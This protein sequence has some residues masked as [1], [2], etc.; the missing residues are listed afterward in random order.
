MKL[1][2]IILFLYLLILNSCTKESTTNQLV[3]TPP[4]T[5]IPSPPNTNPPSTPTISVGQLYQGGMVIHIFTSG[6]Y[7]YISGQTH[8]II[9][10]LQN[11]SGAFGSRVTLLNGEKIGVA[12][13]D[14]C[15]GNVGYAKINT[16]RIIKAFTTFAT[17]QNGKI[18]NPTPFS[19]QT[20]YAAK[21]CD[22]LT[23]NNYNDWYLPTEA[24]LQIMVVLMASSKAN[25]VTIK[26]TY[27]WFSN[28]SF[29]TYFNWYYTGNDYYL[30][31]GIKRSGD[32]YS[33]AGI[34]PIRYF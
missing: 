16:L 7:G 17:M 18:V 6:D 12:P 33:P 5:T 14:S 4:N 15:W 21:I 24:E 8:G 13:V 26:S 22:T 27:Y 20:A 32:P 25:T 11:Y 1:K 30:T 23:L 29:G 19:Y 10:S 28:T 31:D 9:A 2:Q 34:K 3:T